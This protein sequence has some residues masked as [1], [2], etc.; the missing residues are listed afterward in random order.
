MC[1]A[2]HDIRSPLAT[3]KLITS[4]L[5]GLSEENKKI[6][7]MVTDRIESI[8]EDFLSLAKKNKQFLQTVTS[9]KLIEII[10]HLIAEKCLEY[11]SES[12]I[13]ISLSHA[14]S[15]PK[16]CMVKIDSLELQRVMSNLINNS[17]QSFEEQKGFVQVIVEYKNGIVNIIIKDNGKGIHPKIISHLLKKGATFGKTGGSGLGL[18]HAKSTV[19][20]WG[21]K[22]KLTSE[23]GVGTSIIIVLPIE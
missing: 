5:E 16:N 2:A 9:A 7:D 6:L 21:G 3:L 23:F 11:A 20:S 14:H 12:G 4:V 10:N 8:A 22:L 19:E 18:Y 1:K 15:V 17:V 13:E